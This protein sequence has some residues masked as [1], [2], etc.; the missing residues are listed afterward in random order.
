MKKTLAEAET[1]LNQNQFYLY[2]QFQ[3]FGEPL[4]K[5]QYEIQD[6]SGNVVID[7]LSEEQVISI[8]KMLPSKE[9]RISDTEKLMAEYTELYNNIMFTPDDRKEDEELM[10]KLKDLAIRLSTRYLFENGYT[11]KKDENGSLCLL[12]KEGN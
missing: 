3:G 8:S 9:T 12:E 7:H 5:N 11:L 2:H 10:T 1:I 4:D 6:M